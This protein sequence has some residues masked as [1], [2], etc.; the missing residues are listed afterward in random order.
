MT[1]H[2]SHV[3]IVILAAGKGTRM[4]SDLPK[5]LHHVG[6][7]PMLGYVLN[8]GFSLNPAS[9][10]VVVGHMAENV[11]ASIASAWP[12]VTTV[13]QEPQLGTAHAV[14]QAEPVL[15]GQSGTVVLLYGD[16]PLLRPESV[17]KLLAHHQERDAVL[18]VLT[19][20]V[21]NPKGYGRIVRDGAGQVERIVEERD[22]SEEQR[23][24]A[25]I[26]SGIYAFALEP[27]F[28]ALRQIA[29]TNS[30]NEYYLTDLVEIYRRQG[31]TVEA[32]A[33]DDPDELLGVNSREELAR[34]NAILR[35]Q[36]NRQIMASGVTL[37]DPA[38]TWI[39]PDVEIGQDTVIQPN[40]YLE[41]RTQIGRN[42]EIQAGV[43]II[44]STLADQV[45]V[46]N[47]TIIR[48]S[49]VASGAILGPFTHIRPES[50]IESGAHVGN[51]VELKKTRLGAGSKANHLAYLGDAT[52][53]ERV[54]VGAGVI[55]CNYD[56]VKKHPT[57]I[58]DGV[59]VGSDSQLVAPVRIGNDSYIA[60]GS[61]ITEDVPSGAL[62]ISRGRQTNKEGWAA[63]KKAMQAAEQARLAELKKG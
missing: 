34:M 51:F 28:D 53:G 31:R 41:G 50:T 63:K 18:T 45:L 48:N 2:A 13:V 21:K 39:G 16:V 29:T 9:A 27:L 44:D 4:K 30:Q 46:Q 20:S 47:Y 8:A 56:G 49:N 55:T 61:S 6:G 40:V 37:V 24:I 10:T 1:S 11:R 17:Q 43:R 7:A 60:A 57:I 58:E 35:D 52:I 33:I 26:N 19:A 32:L 5:V 62:A 23:A 42:C 22:A 38:T 54:N 36:R 25:E 15:Q 12:S 59:F 14:M 3:H